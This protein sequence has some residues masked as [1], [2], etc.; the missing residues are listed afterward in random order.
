MAKRSTASAT[1]SFGLVAIPVK[2]YLTSS[3]D[4]V[5]FNLL[6]KNKNRVKMKFVDE[7]TGEEILKDECTKIYEHT[8]GQYVQFTKE[9]LEKFG[10]ADGG[11]M[12][13]KEFIPSGELDMLHV[14]KSYYLDSGKGGDRAY[15][16]LVAALLKKNVLAVAQW[17]NRGRTHLMMVG[18]R[19][20]GLIA[21]QMYYDAEV[22]EFELD[23]ATYNPKDVEVDMACR[24]ID[25][26]LIDKFD[27]TKYENEYNKRVLA[28]VE[29][30]KEG[31]QTAD[32]NEEPVAQPSGDLMAALMASVTN[33][34]DKADKAKAKAPK[35]KA[36]KAA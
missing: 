16:L 19:G 36:G 22:R 20:E 34:T 27:T 17:T 23:C 25:T 11:V 3:S 5:G 8:K 1:I 29:A 2:F 7:V 31:K 15:R 28:A 13:I 14:E 35:A 6:T 9:E 4:N 24:L 32:V 21:Y 18:V 26:I 10:D 12:D 30:K 33:V